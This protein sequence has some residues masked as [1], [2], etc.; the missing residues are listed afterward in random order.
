MLRLLAVGRASDAWG[1]TVSIPV[2]LLTAAGAAFAGT[3]GTDL[4]QYARGRLKELLP[5]RAGTGDE[6]AELR[7][8]D[9]LEQA[10]AALEPAQRQAF[11]KG[12]QAPIEKIIAAS[13]DDSRVEALAEFVRALQSKL[14]ESPSVTQQTVTG[15]FAFGDINTAGRD[16]TFGA[17]R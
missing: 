11:S 6:P 17:D 9:T 4:Y 8:L 13:V 12:V 7:Q 14:A 5:A 10:V 1:C 15:N 2:D 16:N 3:M